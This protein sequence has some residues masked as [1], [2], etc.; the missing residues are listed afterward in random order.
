MSSSSKHVSI[1]TDNMGIE[2][3]SGILEHA[4][5]AGFIINMAPCCPDLARI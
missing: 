1:E 5:K 3:L 4:E 2:P